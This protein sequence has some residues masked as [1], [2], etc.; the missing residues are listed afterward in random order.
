MKGKG[1]VLMQAVA[2]YREAIDI[3]KREK[4]FLT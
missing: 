1:E 3:I 2:P 4:D